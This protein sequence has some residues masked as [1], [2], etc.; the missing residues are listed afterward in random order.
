M[1]PHILSSEAITQPM[2]LDDIEDARA[3]YSM[4]ELAW[5]E[6][7]QVADRGPSQAEAARIA[8]GALRRISAEAKLRFG[9][10]R[11]HPDCDYCLEVSVFGGPRHEP[12]SMCRSGKR[13]HC[14]CRACY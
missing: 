5:H 11:A 14:T 6:A 13:A 1:E 8:H 4:L 3:T 10:N 7:R 12:S 2:L 9:N